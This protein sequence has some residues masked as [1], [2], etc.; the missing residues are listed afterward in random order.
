MPLLLALPTIIAE[1]TAGALA[2]K[3]L[4]DAFKD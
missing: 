2:A 3:A 1:I 4:C